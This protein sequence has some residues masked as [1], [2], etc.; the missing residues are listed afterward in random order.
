MTLRRTEEN[1]WMLPGKILFASYKTVWYISV[2]CLSLYVD[3]PIIE[4]QPTLTN[5]FSLLM[6]KKKKKK[7]ELT[8]SRK[9]LLWKQQN[10]ICKCLYTF[11]RIGLYKKQCSEAILKFRPYLS[12]NTNKFLKYMDLKYEQI[13][14]R[15]AFFKSYFFFKKESAQKKGKLL[16]YKIQGAAEIFLT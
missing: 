7:I 10:S 16:L 8:I 5:L 4:W 12:F 1:E 13:L 15:P 9:C 6:D 2:F 3:V 14:S 11:I